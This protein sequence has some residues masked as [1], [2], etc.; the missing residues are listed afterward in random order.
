M[1]VKAICD[2][3]DN[4]ATN[5]KWVVGHVL[6][7]NLTYKVVPQWCLLVFEPHE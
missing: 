1:E 2:R 7:G 6:F 4:E 5:C 3:G